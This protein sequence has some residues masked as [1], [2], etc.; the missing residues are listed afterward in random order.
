MLFK[1]MP[2]TKDLDRPWQADIDRLQQTLHEV[3]E[4]ISTLS[5]VTLTGEAS[6][7]QSPDSQSPLDCKTLK[8]RIRT[9]L[10]TFASATASE[11]ARQAETQTRIALSALH[12]EANGQVEQ[13]ARELREKLKGQLEPGH[14]EIGVT[15]QTQDR[16]AELVQRRTDEFA[17]WVWLMCK[18]TG[19]SIPVQIEKLLEPY[20]D[21]ATGRFS[22]SFR[23]RF[24]TQLEE[25]EQLAQRRLQGTL[26][27]LDEQVSA[28][29]QKAKRICEQNADS[30]ATLSVDRMNGVADEAVRGFRSRIL[31]EL[32]EHFALFHTRLEKKAEELLGRLLSEEETKAGSFGSRIAGLESEIKEKA[33]AQ[34]A[35][36]IER[37]S[38]DVI[39]S[40]IHHLH[41]QANDTLEHSKEELKGF[42]ELQMEETRLKIND[43]GQS[44]QG[45][46][47][48]EAERRADS[49]KKLDEEIVGIREKTIADS[50][51][52]LSAMAQGA[53]DSMRERIRQVSGSQLEE[54]ERFVRGAREKE[55]SQYESHLRDITDSWYNNLLERIQTEAGNAAA[56]V[57]AEVKANSDS[58]MQELSDKVDASALVLREETIQ[59]TSR[60]ESLLKSSLEAYEKQ[61]EEVT[62]N[63]IEEH[64]EA[65]RKSLGDLQSRLARSA[66]ILQ[67][68]ISG[69][70]ERDAR[71]SLPGS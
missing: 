16:V 30:I 9:D 57:S 54:I 29:D 10:E 55:S 56:K 37:T 68:E 23:H 5:G 14:F 64:R 34:L 66:Q 28:L 18:G 3:L 60:I 53:L 42:L 36:H 12:S 15:Q 21:E 17:R 33:M 4:A 2:E 62:G 19:T 63:R 13:V 35:G 11:M 52:H 58:V 7:P 71:D 46:L 32:E 27:S 40:S 38:S 26:S 25:Q 65:I 41:Q 6:D 69:T 51:E 61:L 70:L 20:V 22:E 45:S 59:A 48:Q 31:E 1:Q 39:E 49:L 44:V 8:D 50:K 43:L 47:S 24:D 67:Q